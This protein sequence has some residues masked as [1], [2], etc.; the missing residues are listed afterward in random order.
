MQV[1]VF[2]Y[3]VILLSKDVLSSSNQMM[4]STLCNH[5]MCVKITY[6]MTTTPYLK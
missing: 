1:I 2:N 6:S 3:L 5:G 4:N